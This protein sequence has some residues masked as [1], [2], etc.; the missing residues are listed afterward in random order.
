M[1]AKGSPFKTDILKLIYNGAAVADLA[2][3][4]ATSP[5]TDLYLRLHTASPI[6]GDQSTNEIAY[7]GY[8]AKAVAR[9]SAEWA[10]SAGAA[11]LVNAQSF[12][13]MTGGAGGTVTHISVGTAATG[14]GYLIHVITLTTP[15]AIAAGDTPI[16]AAGTGVTED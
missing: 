5:A 2:E 6:G 10:V 14:A 16:V 12:P 11:T 13:A 3:N 8:A 4:D 9:T 7:T 15:K 1:A